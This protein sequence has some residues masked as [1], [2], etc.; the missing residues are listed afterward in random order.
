MSTTISATQATVAPRQMGKTIG[1]VGLLLLGVASIVFALSFSDKSFGGETSVN[2][3]TISPGF[4]MIPSED[5]FLLL[6]RS[7]GKVWKRDKY[8]GTWCEEY[9]QGV[10]V[11][12]GSNV[13]STHKN[14]YKC[15]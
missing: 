8:S 9:V 3:P 10:T 4:E 6:D 14:Q 11:V 5:T 7:S 2:A 12:P 13:R 15:T 1:G